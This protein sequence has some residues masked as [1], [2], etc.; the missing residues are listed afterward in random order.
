MQGTARVHFSAKE[1]GVRPLCPARPFVP[2][3]RTVP[4]YDRC[5]SVPF[6]RG[7]ALT[8]ERRKGRWKQLLSQSRTSLPPRPSQAF[9][10]TAAGPETAMGARLC[11]SAD[12]AGEETQQIPK[13]GHSSAS[14]MTATQACM[15]ITDAASTALL[16]SVPPPSPATAP[17][18]VA[19]TATA[20]STQLSKEGEVG[21]TSNSAAIP[22]TSGTADANGHASG[23]SSTATSS[24]SQPASV[25]CAAQL[26]SGKETDRSD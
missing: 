12:D 20:P 2:L 6:T 13:Q 22:S 26:A 25:S 18:A 1:A 19:A 14:T 11:S 21:S 5:R 7:D 4:L 23:G 8:A 24:H 3:S 15:A 16:P 9:L 10:V 17:A